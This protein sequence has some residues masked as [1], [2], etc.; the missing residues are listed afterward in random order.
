MCPWTRKSPLNVVS[1]WAP[2]WGSRPE[3]PC[4]RYCT[5]QV[6]LLW[7]L[8]LW[9]LG[10]FHFLCLLII[11]GENLWISGHAGMVFWSLGKCFTLSVN[12]SH[13]IYR[14]KNCFRFISNEFLQFEMAIGDS[15]KTASKS[16]WMTP[17]NILGKGW[18]SF[19]SSAYDPTS[20]QLGTQ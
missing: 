15:S 12:D 2:E 14:E 18:A 7:N 13:L 3:L 19:W 1:H 16:Y 6:L 17:C 8:S 5:L 10:Q 11:T 20:Q 4:Q 9:N